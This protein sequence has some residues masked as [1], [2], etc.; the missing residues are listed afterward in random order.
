MDWV[1]V[2]IAAIVIWVLCGAVM[3]FGRRLI[4]L[5]ATLRLHLVMAPVFSFCVTLI[6]G[7]L[8]SIPGGSFSRAIVITAVVI[9]LDAVIV[10]P[11]IEKS[12]AMFRSLIGTWIPFVLIFLGSWAAGLIS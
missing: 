7:R 11:L 6:L 12:Y 8:T 1:P 5:D 3:G 9:V 2:V 10:A 4:G